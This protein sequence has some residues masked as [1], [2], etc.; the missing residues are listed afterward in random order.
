M[1]SGVW[2]LLLNSLLGRSDSSGSF[3]AQN[4]NEKGWGDEAGAVR[5]QNKKDGD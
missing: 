3:D 5:L 2:I 4:L 1:Y